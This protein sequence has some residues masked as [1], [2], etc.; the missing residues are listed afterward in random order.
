MSTTL[1]KF[2]LRRDTAANLSSVVLSEGEPAYS[3]DTHVLKIGDGSTTWNSLPTLNSTQAGLPEG[4]LYGDYLYWNGTEW[5]TGGTDIHYGLVAGYEGQNF[6]SVAIGVAAGTQNQG[7]GAVGVGYQAGSITQE[8]GAIAIGMD[9]GKESQ[10]TG[11]VAIGYQAGSRNQGERSIAIGSGAG[12]TGLSPYTII[13]NASGNELTNVEGQLGGF[14]VS[15][16]LSYTGNTGSYMIYDHVTKEITYNPTLRNPIT[17]Q[18]ISDPDLTLDDPP[19]YSFKFNECKIPQG[20]PATY[21]YFVRST[22]FGSCG[23][24]LVLQTGDVVFPQSF[25]GTPLITLDI[26]ETGILCPKVVHMDYYALTMKIQRL[27]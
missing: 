2:K 26:V 6:G 19:K 9:A 13:L 23:T 3:T 4:V 10:G 15:P 8:R 22:S 16:I 17:T 20:V 1:V 18:T 12:V 7:T 25:G 14:Y 5:A 11:A 24:I 27:L 21:N